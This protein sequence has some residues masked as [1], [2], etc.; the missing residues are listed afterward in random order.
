MSH[1]PL[2]MQKYRHYKSNHRA[3]S[4]DNWS[5]QEYFFVRGILNIQ[6]LHLLVQLKA[7]M[8]ALRLR[9]EHFGHARILDILTNRNT[10]GEGET[11]SDSNDH[12]FDFNVID[13]RIRDSGAHRRF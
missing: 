9:N 2:C 11:I 5:S 12:L 6:P 7:A 10:L 4:H 1:C 3:K 8:S 13:V